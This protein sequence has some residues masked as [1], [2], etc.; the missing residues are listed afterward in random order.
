MQKIRRRN[1]IWKNIV[2]G[3]TLKYKDLLSTR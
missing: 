3:K 2:Y 1:R